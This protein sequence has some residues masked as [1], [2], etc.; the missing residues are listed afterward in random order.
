MVISSR[1][2]TYLDP[3]Y[4]H[5]YTLIKSSISPQQQHGTYIPSTI[6]F[7][8][9]HISQCFSL[10][11]CHRPKIT[12]RHTNIFANNQRQNYRMIHRQWHTNSFFKKKKKHVLSYVNNFLL[13]KYMYRWIESKSI[14]IEIF[15]PAYNGPQYF[16]LISTF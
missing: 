1:I 10:Y 2:Y 11:S 6:F 9:W 13:I 14:W 7:I 12:D 5:T 15:I 16:W 8:P 3:L 4:I